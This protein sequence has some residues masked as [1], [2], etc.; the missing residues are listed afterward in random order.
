MSTQPVTD[1][2]RRARQVAAPCAESWAPIGAQGCRRRGR[3]VSCWASICRSGV[4]AT[5]A[6]QRFEPNAFIR[7]DRQGL[8]TLVMPQ[9][10]MG[11]G[12][13]TG[14]AMVLAEELDVGCRPGGAG[15]RATQ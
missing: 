15:N 9:V 14:L 4:G 2:V 8:V 5:P 12:I 11:Q 7:I 13:Y 6:P 1:S 10:E 3:R